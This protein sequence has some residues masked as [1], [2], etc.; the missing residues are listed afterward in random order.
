MLPQ[1]ARILQVL[2]IGSLLLLGLTRLDFSLTIPQAL[3]SWS[4]A[5]ATQT[6]CS[7]LTKTRFDP[8]SALITGTSLCLLLRTDLLILAALGSALAIASKF[9]IR[10]NN[11]HIFNPANFGLA[12]IMLLTPH[13]WSSPGQWGSATELAVLI[14]G[15]GTLVTVRSERWDITLFFLISWACI[16]YGRAWYLGDPG[17]IPLKQLK[18]GA[19]LVFSFFMISDPRSTPDHRLGRLIFAVSVAFVAGFIQFGLYRTNGMIWGLFLLSPLTPILDRLLPA[20]RFQ[21]LP[22]PS[23]ALKDARL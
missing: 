10:Y 1:D 2:F 11:K 13:V 16:V 19:V 3:L 6:L 21:W 8:R 12:T 9:L 20:A 5:L 15:L 7:F 23:L 18:S 17:T 22:Q 4:A 14:A